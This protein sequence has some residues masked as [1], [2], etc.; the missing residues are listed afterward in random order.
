MCN[1]HIHG[2]ICP[3][4]TDIDISGIAGGERVLGVPENILLV[5]LQYLGGAVEGAFNTSRV[6]DAISQ[7]LDS[8]YMEIFRY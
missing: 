6:A 5:Q 2:C 7:L 3:F 8:V 4:R 1:I